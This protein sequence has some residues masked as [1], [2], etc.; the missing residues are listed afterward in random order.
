MGSTTAYA[1][2]TLVTLLGILLL[3]FVVL[4]GAKRLGVGRASGPLQLLGRLPLDG[5][6]SVYLVR[7][8]QKSYALLASETT[9]TKLDDVDSSELPTETPTPP[10]FAQLLAKATSRKNGDRDAH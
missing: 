4:F 10:L 1:I 8:G 5:R 2:E 3:S 7:V 6:K 9:L